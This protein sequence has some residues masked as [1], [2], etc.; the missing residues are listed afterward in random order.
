MKTRFISLLLLAAAVLSCDETKE[1]T[2]PKLDFG[3]ADKE[4]EKPVNP[5]GDPLTPDESRVRLEEIGTDVINLMKPDSQE[6]LLAVIDEFYVLAEDLEVEYRGFVEQAMKTLFEPMRQVAKGNAKAAEDYASVQYTYIYGLDQL[7]GIYTHD[8]SEWTYTESDKKFELSFKVGGQRTTITVTPSG[9]IY[10]YDYSFEYEEEG[11]ENGEWVYTP[12]K[13]TIVIKVPAKI[14]ASVV[15]GGKTLADLVIEGKYKVASQEPI[16]TNVSLVM[17]P[18][19]VKVGAVLSTSELSERI[20]FAIDG[21]IILNTKAVANG[22][23]N[24]DP[25]YYMIEDEPTSI[26]AFAG[27]RSAEF[28]TK[29]L[30][31][32]LDAECE[33]IQKLEKDA[34]D[35]YATVDDNEDN[36]AMEIGTPYSLSQ[37][38]VKNVCNLFNKAVTVEASY[39]D[40]P[41]FATLE[42]KAQHYDSLYYWDRYEEY[43]EGY[44]T[45]GD[46]IDD[47]FYTGYYGTEVEVE[48]YEPL[49]IIKFVDDGGSFSVEE[50][51]NEN[52]FTN[53]IDDFNNLMELYMNCLPNITE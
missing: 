16:T 28:V 52:D 34:R 24:L 27:V 35:L 23:F 1:S 21:Q 3:D 49:P 39:D 10:D 20:V 40:G 4:L 8:G 17:G 37:P 9:K 5:T 41:T 29:I 50:F 19:E 53:V 42:L 45:D 11:Y 36:N 13:E 22:N 46:G 26:S 25:E 48:G 32:R 33:D 12:C 30:D 15:K 7:T 51:F 18:Y 2:T 31:L 14:E 38:F 44:D 47:E 6:E 43:T